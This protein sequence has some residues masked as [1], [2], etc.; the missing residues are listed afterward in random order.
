V[1]KKKKHKLIIWGNTGGD[2]LE[3]K[4]H[5]QLLN[6]QLVEFGKKGWGELA[7][8]HSGVGVGGGNGKKKKK[9]FSLAAESTDEILVA[10]SAFVTKGER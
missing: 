2:I 1:G 7:P 4:K 8:F 5:I 10:V 6:S 9:C 3:R